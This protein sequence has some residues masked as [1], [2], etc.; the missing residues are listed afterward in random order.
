MFPCKKKL[1]TFQD[2]TMKLELIIL[3]LEDFKHILKLMFQE[4]KKISKMQ[5]EFEEVVLN[6]NIEISHRS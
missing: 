1:I 3:S 5:K 4:N 2:M 6:K